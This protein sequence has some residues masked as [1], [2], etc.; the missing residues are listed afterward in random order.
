[1]L[2]IHGEG[3]TF[4]VKE[5]NA[6]FPNYVSAVNSYA[7]KTVKIN[8]VDLLAATKDVEVMTCDNVKNASLTISDRVI[9]MSIKSPIGNAS[10]EL[11]FDH[12]DTSC[13]VNLPMVI[14]YVKAFVKKS[15]IKLHVAGPMRPVVFSD[16]FGLLFMSP[17][18]V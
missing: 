9:N 8:G 16:D 10:S 6:V 1:M 17:A 14:D 15:D 12:P 3:W 2:F 5:C 13:G 18:T 11:P 7:G 4:C